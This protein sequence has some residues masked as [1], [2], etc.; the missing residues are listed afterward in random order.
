MDVQRPLLGEQVAAHS[1]TAYRRLRAGARAAAFILIWAQSVAAHPAADRHALYLDFSDGTG[2]ITLGE[3]DDS[4]RNTSSLCGA[5][6]LLRW[7]GAADCP[8]RDSCQDAITE[9]VREH[10][11]DFALDVTSRRPQQSYTTI[12]IAPASGDCKFGV[13]GLSF[14]DC[15][16]ASQKNLGFAFACSQTVVECAAVIAHEA[17]H[18]F[19]LDHT[20]DQ[21]DLMYSGTPGDVAPVF[22]DRELPVSEPFCQRG[23]QNSHSQLLATLGERAIGDLEARDTAAAAAGGCQLARASSS[24]QFPSELPLALSAA[25]VLCFAARRRAGIASRAWTPA[26]IR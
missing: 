4:S 24:G 14:N 13:R 2:E 15:G 22:L 23:T 16:D 20:S 6:P 5:S 10:F 8:D 12:V 26:P 19:G 21:R 7:Q 11:R 3:A 25:L 1:A 9:L 17:G 18:T